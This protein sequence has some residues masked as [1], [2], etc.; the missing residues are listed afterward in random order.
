M[1][2]GYD[3]ADALPILEQW[4]TLSDDQIEALGLGLNRL[5]DV[6]ERLENG[7]LMRVV[8]GLGEC[9]SGPDTG[10]CIPMRVPV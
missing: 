6:G 1:L 4:E 5:G 8:F 9:R 3:L 7:N 10:R 2:G